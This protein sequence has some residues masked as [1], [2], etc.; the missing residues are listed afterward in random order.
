MMLRTI[1]LRKPGPETV[2]TLSYGVWPGPRARLSTVRTVSRTSEPTF[3]NAAKSWV[4]VNSRA[5]SSMAAKSS[6]PTRHT[7]GRRCGRTNSDSCQRV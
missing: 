1:C 2:Q 6:G 3:W 7:K 4:P 5:A